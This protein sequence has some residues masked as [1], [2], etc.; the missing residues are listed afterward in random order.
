[1]ETREDWKE[2]SYYNRKKYI[3]FGIEYPLKRIIWLCYQ[4]LRTP[5][6]NIDNH[7]MYSYLYLE[8]KNLYINNGITRRCIKNY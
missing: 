3:V 7:S 4:V 8:K 1:M 6:Y 5:Y 2:G